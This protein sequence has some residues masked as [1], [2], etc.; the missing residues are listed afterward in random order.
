MVSCGSDGV[1]RYIRRFSA[2]I[3]SVALVIIVLT[4][5]SGLILEFLVSAS[6]FIFDL[7]FMQLCL[8]FRYRELANGDKS[9]HF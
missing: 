6:R 4:G 2:K 3:R 8:F 5:P 7:V 1:L 9:S